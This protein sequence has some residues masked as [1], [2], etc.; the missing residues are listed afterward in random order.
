MRRKEEIESLNTYTQEEKIYNMRTKKAL[1]ESEQPQG[2][3]D[4]LYLQKRNLRVGEDIQLP[5][6]ADASGREVTQ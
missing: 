6:M 5:Y 3:I 2:V 1:L 4:K